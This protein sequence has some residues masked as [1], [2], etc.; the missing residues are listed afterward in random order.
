VRIGNDV[1][2]VQS[3]K[4]RLNA[5]P[6]PSLQDQE[7]GELHTKGERK[8]HIHSAPFSTYCCSVCTIET[9]GMLILVVSPASGVSP[10]GG[11]FHR[12]AA[13]AIGIVRTS[14]IVTHARGIDDGPGRIRSVAFM[15]TSGCAR[16]ALRRI[17]GHSWYL[18]RALAFASFEW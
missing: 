14:Q 7:L 9:S 8:A 10:K 13:T 2:I 5:H 18:I 4:E 6:M 12:S 3:P 16:D 17:A 15:A 11:S 1:Q